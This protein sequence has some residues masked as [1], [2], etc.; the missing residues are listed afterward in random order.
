VTE[1]RE[2]RLARLAAALRRQSHA[3][4][5]DGWFVPGRI[6]IL[7][8]HTD[9][10]GGR[11]LLCA[12]ER[13]ILAVSTPRADRRLAIVDV[14]RGSSLAL[15]PD[16]ESTPLHW[17]TYPLAV[18]RRLAHNFP[19]MTRGADVMF[20]SDLPSASGLS[21]S[22]ALIVLV[23]LAL[24]QANELMSTPRWV[25]NIGNAEDLAAYAA[26]IE[27][28]SSF[29]ALTGASGVGTE[30]GSEDHTAIVCSRAGALAQYSFC[31]TRFERTIPLSSDLIFAIGVS[32]IAARKTGDARD[33]YNRAS[34]SVGRILDRWRAESGRNDPSLAAAVASA[35]DGID[36]LRSVLR[37]EDGDLVDRL[38]QFVEESTILIPAAG[39]RLAAG[40]L[41]G[42][43]T[44]VAR[45][46]E[47]AERLL[48]NQ[49]PATVTLAHQARSLGAIAASAFGAGFGGSVWALVERS[50]APAF[51]DRWQ[52]AYATA[53]REA[54]PNAVFF[55]S[56]AGPGAFGMRSLRS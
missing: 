30:G 19:E 3:P 48:R 26:T 56:G 18:L 51:L 33:D 17:G 25:A 11:S 47:L 53:H 52:N 2:G 21:S 35:P 10:A 50:A 9:Y 23:L 55:S 16:Q 39:D 44:C 46:Q 34:R 38:D 29:R 24:A 31:P 45:S 36:R 40:D 42:F 12:V 5:V 6:E 20:E 14:R 13:G 49:V 8:K 1:D 15:M 22:S 37:H 43:G 28:G 4:E 7:G 41:A 32:G 27:N 54:A